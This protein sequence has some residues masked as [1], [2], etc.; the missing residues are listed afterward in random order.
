MT[1]FIEPAPT[2]MTATVTHASPGDASPVMADVTHIKS[3]RA[4]RDAFAIAMR[5]LS[6]GDR[7]FSPTVFREAGEDVTLIRA[8]RRLVFTRPLE[9]C[10]SPSDCSVAEPT[11]RRDLDRR[12]PNRDV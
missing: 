11:D 12:R 1:D 6:L 4:S 10:I 5:F 9:G 2:G 8:E 7:H 3:V